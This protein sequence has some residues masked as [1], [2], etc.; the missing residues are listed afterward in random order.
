MTV[1]QWSNPATVDISLTSGPWSDPSAVDTT[2]TSVASGPWS[3]PSTVNTSL[4]ATMNAGPNQVE[5]EPGT[6]VTLDSSASTGVTSGRTWTQQSGTA[7]VLSSTTAT[8]PTFIAPPTLSGGVL[9]FRVTDNSSGAVDDVSVTI[10][11]ASRRIK[12][13]GIM[14]PSYRRA[15][16]S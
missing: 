16:I 6:L 7:V 15:M 1:G 11:P 3:N 10:F 9:T 12:L 13:G 4:S 8:M 5:V 14:V 2:V